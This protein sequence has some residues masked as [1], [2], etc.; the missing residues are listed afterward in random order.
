MWG[1]FTCS[2]IC[3]WAAEVTRRGCCW[4]LRSWWEFFRFFCLCV[5][6][7]VNVHLSLHVCVCECVCRMQ[8]GFWEG[9]QQTQLVHWA[10]LH[11]LSLS[12]SL[13]Y[14]DTHNHSHTHTHTPWWDLSQ[15]ALS[16]LNSEPTEVK[17]ASGLCCGFQHIILPPPPFSHRA[18][19]L[20]RRQKLWHYSYNKMGAP[21]IWS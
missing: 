20:F 6:V 16:S 11:P 8:M 10:V 17:E 2:E 21:C 3:F 1:V 18:F 13:S 4:K 14:V 12:H 15:F 19:F 5:C 9:S 7:C